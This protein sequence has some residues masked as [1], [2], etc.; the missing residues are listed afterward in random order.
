MGIDLF[1]TR[2][3]P[4]KDTLNDNKLAFQEYNLIIQLNK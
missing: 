1:E 3:G 2:L 4:F